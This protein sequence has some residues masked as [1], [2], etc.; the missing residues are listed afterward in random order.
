M[1]CIYVNVTK[2]FDV[3]DQKPASVVVYD[4]YANGWFFL[5]FMVRIVTFTKYQNLFF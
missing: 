5:T 3:A 4:Y 2:V 1:Q